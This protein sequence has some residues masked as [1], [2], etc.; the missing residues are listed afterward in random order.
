[1]NDKIFDFEQLIMQCWG[2]TEDLDLLS[3]EISDVEMRP[4]D[5]D[6]LL[7]LAGGMKALT[8]KRFERLFEL[9]ETLLAEK[10]IISDPKP[11]S[12]ENN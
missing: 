1:M 2:V 10:Q 4:E 9:F 3:D 11:L 7:N 6:T 8:Q 5:C 12:N